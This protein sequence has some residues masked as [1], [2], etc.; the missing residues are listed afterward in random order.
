MPSKCSSSLLLFLRNRLLYIIMLWCRKTMR[1]RVNK[2]IVAFLRHCKWI[3]T[4]RDEYIDGA[5]SQHVTSRHRYM[6]MCKSTKTGGKLIVSKLQYVSDLNHWQPLVAF[7]DTRCYYF[8]APMHGQLHVRLYTLDF[9]QLLF[10]G[11]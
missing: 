11:H 5:I 7:Y 8:L 2:M 10:V 4:K 9:V 6:C 3:L 1:H